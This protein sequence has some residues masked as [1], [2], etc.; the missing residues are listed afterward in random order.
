MFVD[1][2]KKSPIFTFDWKAAAL[3]FDRFICIDVFDAL[4]ELMI[5]CACSMHALA[6]ARGCAREPCAK[7]SEQIS[8]AIADSSANRNSNNLIGRNV[9]ES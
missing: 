5:S 8:I 4:F 6:R 3:I 9:Y 7:A 2:S 1:S